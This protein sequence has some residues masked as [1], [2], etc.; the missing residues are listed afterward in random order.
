MNK[1]FL[2]VVV[3]MFSF[4]MVF[5][6]ED[7]PKQTETMVEDHHRLA[8][9]VEATEMETVVHNGQSRTIAKFQVNVATES[10]EDVYLKVITFRFLGDD[11]QG[12]NKEL[13][14]YAALTNV[15]VLADGEEL[16]TFRFSAYEITV[17]TP[18]LLNREYGLEMTIIADVNT[19]EE[20]LKGLVVVDQARFGGWNLCGCENTWWD[21]IFDPTLGTTAT[22]VSAL[23]DDLWAPNWQFPVIR[24]ENCNEFEVRL[25]DGTCVYDNC[26]EMPNL[27]GY[28]GQCMT[29]LQNGRMFCEC[30]PGF[31]T[32]PNSDDPACNYRVA[33]YDVELTESHRTVHNG[34]SVLLG[35][36][37]IFTTGGE[38]SRLRMLFFQMEGNQESFSSFRVT[39]ETCLFGGPAVFG[40]L[41][42]AIQ[43]DMSSLPYS[44]E[45]TIDLMFSAGAGF[46]DICPDG[47]PVTIR[48][49]GEVHGNP[50]DYLTMKVKSAGI[51]SADLFYEDGFPL[52][53]E[54]DLQVGSEAPMTS[55]DWQFY[56]WDPSQ[57]VAIFP[58]VEI[59]E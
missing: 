32:T 14:F 48:V 54:P 13:A 46:Y 21:A 20:E 38:A 55:M 27:C 50:G 22:T 3:S 15:R 2:M 44:T 1:Y 36:W 56:G 47:S 23:V 24:I 26:Q 8:Y 10:E 7:E 33:R 11:D 19:S 9:D 39:A 30:D 28:Y 35:A 42:T 25:T 40:D 12:T 37:K 57:Y 34:S 6:C 43:N 16:E 45:Q 5:A 49:Y 59:V 18:V 29:N 41:E 58:R 4:F 17:A 53:F 51:Y 52:G 31:S